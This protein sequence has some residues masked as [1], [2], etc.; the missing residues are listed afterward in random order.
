MIR[1]H[2]LDRTALLCS[3]AGT[4]KTLSPLVSNG[5]K[6]ANDA[7]GS[8]AMLPPFWQAATSLSGPSMDANGLGLL[9]SDGVPLFLQDDRIL[10][11]GLDCDGD[12]SSTGSGL[13]ETA[14]ELGS[15]SAISEVLQTVEKALNSVDQTIELPPGMVYHA[16][17]SS[18]NIRLLWRGVLQ[19]VEKALN[20]VDQ[21]RDHAA[22]VQLDAVQL[23]E[24]VA[25]A[26]GRLVCSAAVSRPSCTRGAWFTP[27]L[28][29]RTPRP[30]TPVPS[31]P[32]ALPP[33]HPPPLPPPRR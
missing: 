1:C 9:S 12:S 17:S 26:Q 30:P 4:A 14:D 29:D 7:S 3:H 27:H 23:D 25:V 20:S 22:A 11:M 13:T 6:L 15:S 5:D 16:C 31:H 10:L 24:R 19:S 33:L 28:R 8:S 2:V 32:C 18:E 21:L